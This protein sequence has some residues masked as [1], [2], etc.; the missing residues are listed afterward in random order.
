MLCPGIS[1]LVLMLG[2]APLEA[3]QPTLSFAREI[4]PMLTTQCLK[5]HSGPRAKGEL[6][7]TRREHLLT[8]GGSGSVLAPGKADDSLLFQYVRDRKCHPGSR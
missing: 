7:L 8:G 4:A 2:G 1:C 6:D 5:C 3:A